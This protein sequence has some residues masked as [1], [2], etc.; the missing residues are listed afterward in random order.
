MTGLARFNATIKNERTQDY[1][2]QVLGKNATGFI[3][4]LTSIVSN[5]AALQDCEPLSLMYVGIKAAALNLPLDPNLGFAYAIPYRNGKTGKTEAQFQMGYKGFVQLAI[6]SGQ[7][8]AINVTDVREGEYLGEDLLTG[9][10]K[11]AKVD[12]REQRKAVGYAAYMRL[13]N[14]FE[15]SLYWSVEKVEAHARQYSQT[16]SSP[17]DYIRN[18]SKWA[19]DFDA[20]ARK[21]VLKMLISKFAPLSIEMQD[22]IQAD[23]AVFSPEGGNEYLDNAAADDTERLDDLAADAVAVDIT[24]A[25]GKA[26]DKTEDK[27]EDKAAGKPRKAESVDIFKGT[28]GGRQ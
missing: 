28:E 6:R 22:A 27:T 1:L 8:K 5:N 24:E 7:F 12:G 11:L 25:A 17:K 13:V 9:E 3:T 23:Q 19:T 16:Y 4:S 26:E 14:G 21:T 20:M 18:S 2:R 10:L 15:K